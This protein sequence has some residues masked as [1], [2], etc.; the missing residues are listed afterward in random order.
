ML[1]VFQEPHFKRLIFFKGKGTDMKRLASS[2]SSAILSSLN[3]SFS[4]PVQRSCQELRHALT[5]SYSRVN[6]LS[7]SSWDTDSLQL[8]KQHELGR[9]TLNMTRVRTLLQLAIRDI[10]SPVSTF[11]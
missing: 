8:T 9:I 6:E 1:S 2:S 7:I 3:G 10:P 4:H 5:E 11:G